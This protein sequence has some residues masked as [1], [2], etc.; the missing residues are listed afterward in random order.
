VDSE[1]EEATAAAEAADKDAAYG[2]E[3]AKRKESFAAQ[4]VAARAQEQMGGARAGAAQPGPAR[5]CVERLAP[6]L[7]QAALEGDGEAV[8]RLLA[9]GAD[10]N[11]SVARRAPDGAVVQATAL[12]AACMFLLLVVSSAD[13]SCKLCVANEYNHAGLKVRRR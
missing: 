1:E 5:D 11:A 10:P 12:C 6:K 13:K 8:A 2:A 3:V 9:A 4:E 7:A